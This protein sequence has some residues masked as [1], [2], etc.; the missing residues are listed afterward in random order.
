MEDQWSKQDLRPFFNF[1]LGYF[2]DFMV[3]RASSL[4]FN[5]FVAK[6]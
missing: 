2:K 5:I 4:Y 1:D 3:S 6:M